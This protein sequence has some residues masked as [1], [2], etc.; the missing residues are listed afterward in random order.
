MPKAKLTVRSRLSDLVFLFR[1]AG[2]LA[3]QVIRDT[4]LYA[5]ASVAGV[6]A[7]LIVVPAALY[8]AFSCPSAGTAWRIVIA[9]TVGWMSVRML[10]AFSIQVF[11]R[12]RDVFRTRGC[13]A[14]TK[15]AMTVSYAAA[16]DRTQ[17]SRLRR[18]TDAMGRHIQAPVPHMWYTLS[19]LT[20]C[21]VGAVLTAVAL[22][23][24]SGWL[25]A[26]TVLS[27]ALSAW[28]HHLVTVSG[29]RYQDR[30]QQAD[31]ELAYLIKVSEASDYA[32]DIRVF[33][34]SGWFRT[35][36]DRTMKTVR[37]LVERRAKIYALF[38]A[39][40][41]ILVL[42]RG[43]AV[44]AALIMTASPDGSEPYLAVW[45][46]AAAGLLA[47]SVSGYL[48]NARVLQTESPAL[49]SY[50]RYI[51]Q[52]DGLKKGDALPFDGPLHTVEL[53]HVTVRHPD[54]GRTVLNDVSFVWHPG[55]HIEVVG[56]DGAGKTTLALVIVGLL[57]PDEGA[58]L[59]DGKDVRMVDRRAY[60]Q[61]FS[62][63]LHGAAVSD[64]TV[65][66][67]VSCSGDTVDETR[68]WR[69]LEQA[70]IAAAVQ[71]LP[72]GSHTPLGDT[73]LPSGVQERLMLASALYKD[74][75]LWLFDEPTAALDPLAQHAWCRDCER[76]TNGKGA[77]FLSHRIGMVNGCDRTL[78]LKD[79][80][81]V[82]EGSHE[83]LIA[84]GGVY[85]SLAAM[86][87]RYHQEGRD[88][89]DGIDE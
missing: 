60:V 10:Q 45:Y 7:Q 41:A 68:L 29:A 64:I 26:V 19:Q 16:V 51:E 57:D 44:L 88:P 50:R 21:A 48:L 69:C 89:H 8:A 61:L 71:A 84:G 72:H 32:K 9:V 62:A 30:E 65:A 36:H 47:Q 54:T 22:S 63:V 43:G 27:A 66:E 81:I 46:V 52:E 55:E 28:V 13:T 33:G 59:I 37:S 17:L 34:M 1:M 39:A 15:R 42:L 5:V 80:C 67:C 70:G 35:L 78:V 75:D 24:L 53:R 11:E 23:A 56:P 14:L 79:G 20:G 85:A 31:E 82:E 25:T 2:Q 58:V 87:G 73:I 4:V 18:A 12:S 40:D 77:I 86:Q 76:L 49:A 6:I 83:D 3:P 38:S 74:G